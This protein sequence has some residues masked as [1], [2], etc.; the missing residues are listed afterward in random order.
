MTTWFVAGGWIMW[1]LSL[2]GAVAIAA[3]IGFA[4][5]P[6]PAKLPR[7]SCLARA[8]AWALV[9]GIVTDLAAV[10]T[11]IPAHPEWAHSPDLP[12]LVLAGVAESMS[13]ATLGG[14]ILS[15]IALLTAVGHG[16]MRH[17]PLPM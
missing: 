10:G 9:T 5:A 2:V 11:N 4:R 15:V 8:V 16:R 1:F 14:A 12:L 13:P 7:L 3:A 6:D 17:A